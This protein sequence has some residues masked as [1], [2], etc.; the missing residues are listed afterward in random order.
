ML[1]LIRIRLPALRAVAAA[2]LIGVAC[3]ATAATLDEQVAQLHAMRTFDQRVATVG[4]RLAVAS[5]DLC[6]DPVWLPGLEL[7]DL[8][9]YGSDSR[10]A[11]IQAFG[12]DSD[13]AVLALAA[14]GPAARAGLA[15]DDHVQSLDGQPLPRAAPDATGSFD[16]MAR[17]MDAIDAAFADGAASVGIERAGAP[18]TIDIVA[19][20]GCPSRFQLIP[21]ARLNALA[22]GRY[23][24]VTTALADYV[25][26][27]DELAA[28]LAHEFAHNILHHRARLDAEHV[29]RGFFGN[30][31]RNA[32][33]IRAT[34][35]EADRLSI[36]LLDRAGYDPEA[37]VRFWSRFGRRRL[38]FLNAPTH[39]DWRRRVASFEAEIVKVR[40][41]RAAGRVP[42]PDF[43][44]LPMPLPDRGAAPAD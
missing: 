24:Q 18:A 17:I 44:Q 1:S 29:S 22:D 12:L 33:L 43:V 20:R 32:R 41:A 23:V 8:S 28:V 21:S 34:E 27:D 13:A 9:E 15:L 6:A 5:R 2:F 30:F 16:R 7:H 31:G 11:A 39:P 3:S 19:V 4:F 35:A 38:S 25:A 42:V 14:D 36:Y 10:A 40:A 37:A 26:D